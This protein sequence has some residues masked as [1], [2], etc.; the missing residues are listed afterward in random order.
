MC[1]IT[2]KLKNKCGVTRIDGARDN[3]QVWRPH[4]QPSNF[5]QRPVDIKSGQGVVYS[6]PCRDFSKRYIGETKRNL[7]TRYNEHKV[8]IK[9]NDSTKVL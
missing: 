1:K 8:D 7:E 2:K 9:T 3:K 4:G 5:H 6:I